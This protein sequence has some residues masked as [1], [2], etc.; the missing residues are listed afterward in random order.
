MAATAKQ[1]RVKYGASAR[2]VVSYKEALR[3]TNFIQISQTFAETTNFAP[4]LKDV[5]YASEKL[6][7]VLQ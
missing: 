5:S 2:Y 3:G 4:V 6:M 7:F 1:S